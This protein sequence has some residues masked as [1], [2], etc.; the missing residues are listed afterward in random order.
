MSKPLVYGIITARGGSK[1][2]PKKNIREIAGKPMI[3]W[4]V[5]S[6]LKAK[7]ID[8]LIC[9]TDSQE[10]ADIAKEYGAEIPFLRPAEH[11]Q[12]LTPDLP[13]FVHAL[14]WFRDNEGKVPDMVVHLRPTGPLRTAE[15]IDAAI[16]LLSAHPEADSVRCVAEAELHPLKTY[17]ITERGELRPFIPESVFGL[18]EAYNMPRQKL[19]KAY[20]SYAYLST[21]WSKT[22]LEKQSMSG[23][24]ILAG[25]VPRANTLDIDSPED[26]EV[27]RVM[28]E[29]RQSSQA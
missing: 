11:A 23:E 19:P 20:A 16:D 4:T 29:R 7:G 3:A 21:I 10:I 8:R 28:L 17:S 2:V 26:F 14:E 6:A 22:I 18:H 12:D 9:S 24:K 27:V 15:D 25:I 5:L 1:S 13:V